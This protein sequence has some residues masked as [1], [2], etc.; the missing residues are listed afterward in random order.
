MS[1]DEIWNKKNMHG[2]FF[3]WT[4][5]L[6]A[7]PELTL[8]RHLGS[9]QT[10]QMNRKTDQ[11]FPESLTT[12][13]SS[14]PG[15]WPLLLYVLQK[16]GRRHEFRA[17]RQPVWAGADRWDFLVGLQ[18]SCSGYTCP[19]SVRFLRSTACRFTI[20][21]QLGTS[22]DWFYVGGLTICVMK[23]VFHQMSCFF[24]TNRRPLLIQGWADPPKEIR[25]EPIWSQ[26]VQS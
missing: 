22:T 18:K 17:M 3:N 14:V 11:S 20:S 13:K 15:V 8:V 10:R 4:S 25:A 2:C 1:Q 24:D 19:V 6:L 7:I 26:S 5:Q 9:L 16:C 23:M 12:S 21:L